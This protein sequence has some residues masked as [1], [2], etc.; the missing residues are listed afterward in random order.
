MG[1]TLVERSTHPLRREVML[2]LQLAMAVFVWTV[3]IGILNGTD[4]VDF[5]RKVV[6][7]HVH[8]GTLGWITTCVFAATLW[9]FGETATP[10]QLRAARWLTRAAVVT[11]P[12][13]AFTFAFTYQEPRA[14]LGSL[15]LA[16]IVGFFT[17]TAVRARHVE[18]TTV[19]LG[20]LAAVATS[21]VGGVLGV[22][23]ATKI[24][25]G[26][27]VVPDGGEDAHPATMV[28]GFLV[29]VGMALAEWGL[30]R[31]VLRPAGRLGR[32][33][34]G[35]PFLG[36]VLLMLG[37]LLDVDALPPLAALIE[38]AGVVIFVA[39]LGPLARRVR[40]GNRAPGR[41]AAAAGIA[42]VVNIVFINY[43]AGA[44][45]GD[46]DLVPEHQLLALDHTM[47]V[48]VLTNAI[49]AMLVLTTPDAA[50]WRRVDGLVFAGMNL[51][52]VG[53]VVS[54]LAEATT[55][56]RIATPLMGAAI[57]GG[58]VEHTLLLRSTTAVAITSVELAP[59][60]T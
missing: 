49:F 46:F 3:A 45:G 4:L 7:S 22:L 10:G 8:A 26:R 13:F 48:G 28:V 37:L 43:L 16:T 27:N 47:F 21:V 57:V 24:A 30:S 1:G 40:W 25:T 35:L 51:G 33:Q 41:F 2:L 12:V 50:R 39:R 56:E 23:L 11:L 31:G 59:A 15:A 29:P 44:N 55:L 18:L 53:F 54:L 5:S 32:A 34:I 19:H 6:L 20:F 42:I 9:L 58:L 52:L 17:W 60:G 14:A 38:L 36:G